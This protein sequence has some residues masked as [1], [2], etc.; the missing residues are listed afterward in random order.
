MTVEQRERSALVAAYPPVTTAPIRLAQLT[1][2]RLAGAWHHILTGQ[3][4]LVASTAGLRRFARQADQRLDRLAQQLDAG[5]YLPRPLIPVNIPKPQGGT[6][7]LAI[8]PVTDR[9]VE[10]A[11]LEILTP[12]IDPHLH[13]AAHAYRPGRGIHTAIQELARRRDD[14]HPWVARTD[15]TDCFD[16]LPAH[17]LPELLSSIIDADLATVIHKLL[18]RAPGGGVPQGAPLSP[19]WCNLLL[20]PLDTTL[21]AHGLS[22]IRYADD[23]AIPTV[24]LDDAHTALTIVR[25]GA[26]Q[27]GMT[28][29]EHKTTIDSFD[30]GFVYLGQECGPRYPL[31]PDIL[32][33]PA[34]RSIYVAVQG[35]RVRIAKGR[36]LID[37]PNTN[38]TAQPLLDVPTRQVARIVTLGAVGV[39][40][41]ARS[42]ALCGDVDVIHLSR[43]G[44]YLGQTLSVSGGLRADRLRAQLAAIDSSDIS[45]PLARAIVSGKL[46]KQKVHLQRL[47]RRSASEDLAR[48]IARITDL[49]ARSQSVTT[50]DSLRGNEGAG[51]HAYFQGL[52]HAVPAELGFTHRARRPATDLVNAALSYGYAILLGETISALY[53]AGL[54]PSL[55]ILHADN[56]KRPGLA[57][58]LME[59]FRPWV[60]DQAVI[61]AIR[62]K[63]LR[64]EHAS[65]NDNRAVLLT[66][67]G[68]NILLTAYETRMNQRTKGAYPGFAGTLRRHLTLQVHRLAH[69]LSDPANEPWSP[70]TWRA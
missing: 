18:D 31:A 28:L 21:T 33:S 51:A 20:E 19:L 56:R 55:G 63:E 49:I 58:D 41:G 7:H 45:L 38:T 50:I 17:H 62:R 34:E 11:I 65:R 36:L 54:E 14:Q 59:E 15:L 1:R 35:A 9:I 67:T 8:P 52:T 6:R 64:P 16:N 22:G 43:H 53:T 37:P 66:S 30:H 10:R 12:A 68:K 42:W 26:A 3:D 47:T 40:A 46:L 13:D 44:R 70:L 24:S 27:L 5:T 29:V 2:E 32:V 69:H 61:A 39:T 60:V 25:A 48:A 4:D 57:L 23:I